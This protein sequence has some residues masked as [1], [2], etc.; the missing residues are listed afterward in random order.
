MEQLEAQDVKD[1][2]HKYLAL[3]ISY[4]NYFH[5]IFLG[6]CNLRFKKVA[7]PRFGLLNVAKPKVFITCEMV[8]NTKPD[9]DGYLQEANL[10]G[11]PSDKCIVFEDSKVGIESAFNG[12][13]KLLV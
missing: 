13:V 6:N 3:V 8:I 10:L 9:P 2:N 4:A 1:I 11:L 12:I 5:L 7:D